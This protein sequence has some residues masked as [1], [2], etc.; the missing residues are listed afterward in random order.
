MIALALVLAAVAQPAPLSALDA[1][2]ARAE[3]RLKLGEREEAESAYRSALVEGYLLVGTLD[4]VDARWTGAH[5]AFLRALGSSA[6]TQRPLVAL[7]LAELQSGRPREAVVRLTQVVARQPKDPEARRLLAQAHI[8]SGRPEQAVQELEEAR[9]QSPGDLELL[10]TLAEGY[11]RVGRADAAEALFA[12]LRRDRPIPQTHVLIGHAYR[13]FAAYDRARQD[14]RAALRLDPRARRAH[15]DLGMV[16]VLD[17][18]V[19]GLDEAIAEFRAELALAPADPAA[20]LA[21]GMALVEAQQPADALP[22][23]ERA[24]AA[25]PPHPNAAQYLGRALLALD[26]PADAVAPLA[27][28]LELAGP[29]TLLAGSVQYQ[30]GL[31]YRG[32]G[33][34]D[35]AAVHFS[36]AERTSADRAQ[37]A[38]ARLSRYLAGESG[39]EAAPVPASA[40]ASSPLAALPPAERAR[41]RA[42]A[43]AAV[44]RA[45]LNL[46][47]LHAQADRVGRAAE[48]F[49]QAAEA[50]PALPGVQRSLGIA[51]FGA[52]RFADA[53]PAL[54]RALR[55]APDDPELSRMLAMAFL[56]AERYDRAAERL[57]RDPARATDPSLEFAYGLALVRGGRGAEAQQVFQRLLAR[58]GDS[59]QLS[60]V[61]GQA[62]AQQGD[63]PSAVEALTR[64]LARQADVAEANAALGLIALKQGR[65]PEAEAALRAELAHHPGDFRARHTL[66]TV[67][68]L[69]GRRGEAVPELRAVLQARPQYADARYLL[70]KVLLAEGQAAEAAEHLEAAARL[71]PDDANIAYQLGQAYTRLGRAERAQQE[72]ARFQALKDRAR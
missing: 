45:C 4:A 3:E 36:A 32:L 29:D 44:A 5:D 56:N 19:S 66:A 40:F 61:L 15:Y 23:L 31:A 27:R 70:G 48:F 35:D 43:N 68:D 67:L 42:R 26:R 57:E 25:V 54:E 69:L 60:V 11:L 53:A 65:L 1:A 59:P 20:T 18:G 55:E 6:E 17:E 47:V 71:A 8:A 34:D 64:A 24:A 33:R 72:F 21:L 52:D 63:Y 13:S 50:D 30:L 9:A 28:A 38:R 49:A 58:H 46:G 16:A 62:Y 7:A 37:G 22:L 51:L 39:G 10:F 41:L 2:V 14:L 12:R